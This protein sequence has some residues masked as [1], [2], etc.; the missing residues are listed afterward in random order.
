MTI[1]SDNKPPLTAIKRPI[2]TYWLVA[3]RKAEP[4]SADEGP[5]WP[6]VAAYNT[7]SFRVPRWAGG[8]P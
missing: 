2:P 5:A 1:N 8:I 3:G 7:V 6:G 4:W